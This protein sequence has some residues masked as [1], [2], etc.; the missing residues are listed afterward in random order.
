M[1]PHKSRYLWCLVE[2]DPQPYDVFDIP[3]GANVARLKAM[4]K[5]RIECLHDT[6]ADRLKLLKL[7]MMVPIDPDHSLAQRL[8]DL[9][10]VDAYLTELSSGEKVGELFPK[11]PSEKH[12]HI[13]VQRPGIAPSGEYCWLIIHRKKVG[14]NARDVQTR[15][16]AIRKAI[17][18]MPDNLDLSDPSTFKDLPCPSPL[19]MPP[20]RFEVKE[21]DGIECFEYMGRS[22][23]HE[24][25][26]RIKDKN[27]QK[28]AESIYLYGTS[29]SGKSHLLVALVYH[30]IRE[31][32]RVFYIPD[33][34][35]L[36]LDPAKTMWDAYRFAYNCSPD[37]RT[38]ESV[39][40]L[41]DSMRT[42]P[43]VYIIVDQVNALE[44]T[45][46]DNRREA[47]NRV[48]GWLGNLRSSHRY[49]FSASAN[50]ASNRDA[51]KRQN[52]ISVFSI[53]GGMSQD[54]TNQWFK[55]HGHRIPSLSDKQR[56][57]VE[58]LTGRIP[59]LLCCLFK[60]TD[61]S[62]PEFRNTPVL[63]NVKSDVDEFARTKLI[64]LKG[65]NK[66]KY[67]EI[68]TA[69]V[70]GDRV[71]SDDRKLYDLRHFYV[72]TKRIG[73]FT[74]G[75]AFEAMMSILR[76]HDNTPFVDGLWYAAVSGSDNPVVQGFLAEQIC[77]SHIATKGLTVVNPK[78]K[79]MSTASFKTQPNF[80]HHLSSDHDVC[81]YIPDDYNFMAVDGV[82]LLLNRTSKKATVFSIQFTLSQNHKQSDKDFHE[83]L[84]ST[85][86]EPIASAGFKV[87]STFVWID[88]EQPSEHVEDKVVKKLRSGRKIVHPKYSV[89]HVG[90]KAV[91]PR[92]A[93]ALGIEQ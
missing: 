70:R 11:L 52:G 37:L 6:C 17:Q 73:R 2:G 49:I 15:C 44:S 76:T 12:L 77:L 72:D 21:I 92:L 88:K 34:S 60:I 85:W 41:I 47:K 56:Q 89:I 54:E 20:E 74:C 22:Q 39:E 26:E 31:G 79:Q 48:L 8:A 9:G 82:I 3:I 78:L 93:Y 83:K 53:F 30:L 4:I 64:L 69:C 38:T 58:Y 32:Q 43:D 57:Q 25:Q 35:S 40:T 45:N 86:T 55:W 1:S 65:L 90:A 91:H 63:H 36:L 10:N 84:W 67:L 46:T 33:C 81:L 13:V 19:L 50:E 23:F 59:L 71:E 62:E 27:F 5:K 18:A 29:G 51:E 28:G 61:F 16:T 75:V 7:N 80:D 66:E 14:G 24:L 42:D 87:R 68:M